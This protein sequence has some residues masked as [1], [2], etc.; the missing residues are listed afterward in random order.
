VAIGF[1]DVPALY[2]AIAARAGRAAV[3]VVDAVTETYEHHLRNVTLVESGAHGMA[4]AAGYPPAS[5]VGRPPM[6][7]TGRLRASVARTPGVGGGGVATASVAPHTI[8]AATVQW[9][10]VHEGDMWLWIHRTLTAHEVYRKGWVR[11]RVEIGPH[12]YMDIAVDE[13]VADGSLSRAAVGAFVTVVW[14]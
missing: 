8:Y 11:R 3:P 1:G 2:E 9:G 10:G 14:A 13:T 4:T 7:M 5:P 6:T 12:N